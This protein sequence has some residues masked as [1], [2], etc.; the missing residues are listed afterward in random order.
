MQFIINSNGIV[1]FIDN[2]PLKFERGSTQYAKILEKFD[3]PETEQEA[4]IREVIQKTSPNAEKNGFKI[5]PESVSYLG[6]ELPQSLADKVRTIHEEGLPLSLFEKFWQNLQLNPSASSVREL[7]EFLEYKELPL[8]EDGC[9]LAYKGLD[10]DFWSISG[11]KET[12]VIK[13]Q[14]NGSGNIFNGVGEKIEVRRWDVDD[15]RENHCSFGLHVGSLD[16]ARSFARGTVVVVK[17]NPKDVVSV[18]NDCKCQKCRVS[19]Y[20]VVSVFEQEI[21]A[22]VVD[23]DNNPIED[24]S[25]SNRSDFINRVEKYLHNKEQKGFKE[26][27]IRS[28]RNSF[29]PEYPDANRVFDALEELGYSWFEND[30]GMMVRVSNEDSDYS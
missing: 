12:K 10:S 3:L 28:I 23:A 27:S 19:A 24:E 26:V 1:L 9:F 30:D 25:N 21:T 4:A 16:Y 8:T 13:G 11:D 7:Y 18:P 14:V 2:K 5:S 17:I 29:S 20:E 15:N 22:A 6:E